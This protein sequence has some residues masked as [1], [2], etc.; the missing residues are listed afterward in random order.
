MTIDEQMIETVDELINKFGTNHIVTSRDIVQIFNNQYNRP[1]DSVSPPDY[2]YNRINNGIGLN[3]PAVFEYM[4]S[5]KYK[6][7]GLDY[8][9]NGP[10]YHK[11]QGQQEIIVGKCIDGKR[12]IAPEDGEET[13]PEK[14]TIDKEQDIN[15]HK[16]KRDPGMGLRFQINEAR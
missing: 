10:I 16:T 8:P 5:S 6:C 9:Y 4:G 7:L 14:L 15:K 1:M 2:C 3:K 13:Q 12:I 11:P